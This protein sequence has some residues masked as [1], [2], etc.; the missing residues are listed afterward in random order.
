MEFCY[1][2][3]SIFYQCSNACKNSPA[4]VLL[5]GWGADGHTFDHI[6]SRLAP[7]TVYTIDLPGFGKSSEPPWV[8]DLGDYTKMLKAFIDEKDIK[9]PILL[10]H[11]FG[12]RIAINYAAIHGC[13]KL[14]LVDSAG[15]SKR[16]LKV[17]FKILI[18][19]LGKIFRKGVKQVG[20]QD[21][22][23]SSQMM[24]MVMSKI[25]PVNQ[26]KQLRRISAE[27]LLIWGGL[28]HTTPVR[29]GILMNR[30]IKNSGLVVFEN[31]GHFPYLEEKKRFQLVL[32]SF[33]N[34]GGGK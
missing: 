18:Y 31:S 27:T 12:G 16:G 8:F 23:A 22:Q 15:V 14:I 6:V 17:R 24:K 33:L 26:K 20:S 13:N 28:D 29:D 2:G 30:L 34:L 25:V 11:S 9:D 7:L 32:E 19:K 1:L 10:G 4:I 21:Y 3:C 5:H